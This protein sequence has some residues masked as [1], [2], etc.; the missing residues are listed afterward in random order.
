M[1]HTIFTVVFLAV[2]FHSPTTSA[3]TTLMPLVRYTWGGALETNWGVGVSFGT[4]GQSMY[5]GFYGLYSWST[6]GVGHSFSAGLHNS[7]AG[8]GG[9]TLGVTRMVIKKGPR[10]GSY[11]GVEVTPVL[12]VLALRGALMVGDGVGEIPFM[13]S[14]LANLE[15]GFGAF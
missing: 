1:R 3:G 6:S 15:W 9:Y 14:P 4:I 10:R 5:E 7:A 2:I 8:M 13:G 11:V 12:M